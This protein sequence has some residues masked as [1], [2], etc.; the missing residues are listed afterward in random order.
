MAY[1]PLVSR[2]G[3]RRILCGKLLVASKTL[4]GRIGCG[5]VW[6]DNR[7]MT[8][9]TTLEPGLRHLIFQTSALWRIFN[10]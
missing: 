9:L 8:G 7:L 5:G 6:R 2:I 1:E 10:V 3:W 4:R